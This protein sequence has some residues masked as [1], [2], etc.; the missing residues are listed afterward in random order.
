MFFRTAGV[1]PA[2]D[3]ERFGRSNLRPEEARGPEDRELFQAAR[4][5]SPRRCVHFV[6]PERGIG[7]FTEDG[8]LAIVCGSPTLILDG[9]F[10]WLGSRRLKR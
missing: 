10:L 4:R 7:L 8:E 3:H 6:A 9:V 1:P 5:G 2:Q